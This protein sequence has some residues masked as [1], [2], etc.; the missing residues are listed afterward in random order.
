MSGARWVCSLKETR[1]IPLRPV[2]IFV[3][4]VLIV[5]RV[6]AIH[7][8]KSPP[9]SRA[10]VHPIEPAL[11]TTMV[12]SPLP[13]AARASVKARSTRAVKAEWVSA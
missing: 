3:M 8:S 12:V 11:E 2:T 7:W 4:P 1:L 10:T 6:K 5:T 9:M 13:V